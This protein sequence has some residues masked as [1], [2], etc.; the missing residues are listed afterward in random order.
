M[1]VERQEAVVL[2]CSSAS[3]PAPALASPTPSSSVVPATAMIA[4][5]AA[6]STPVATLLSLLLILYQVYDL[7]RYSQVFDLSDT[8][9]S[10]HETQH[11]PRRSRLTLLPLT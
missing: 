8:S 4:T 3:S 1:A 9:A 5:S 11:T 6:S 7:V 2:S 10:F